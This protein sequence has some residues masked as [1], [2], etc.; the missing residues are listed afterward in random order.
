MRSPWP[1]PVPRLPPFLPRLVD[2]RGRLPLVSLAGTDLGTPARPAS[3]RCTECRRA[4]PIPEWRCA[5]CGAALH[6][7]CLASHDEIC[8]ERLACEV[9]SRRSASEIVVGPDSACDMEFWS[10]HQ[11]PV[12]HG[13]LARSDPLVWV[14]EGALGSSRSSLETRFIVNQLPLNQLVYF[15]P[16]CRSFVAAEKDALKPIHDEDELCD[17]LG[18]EAAGVCP[19]LTRS[20]AAKTRERNEV[21]RHRPGTY[22]AD[23]L[24]PHPAP[25]KPLAAKGEKGAEMG[26]ADL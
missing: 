23:P 8:M 16:V 5:E 18:E 6:Q 4:F 21:E 25:K 24:A 1:A 9:R 3:P 11:H 14:H 15:V 19:A 13:G 17:G 12:F 22:G 26:P 7:Q 2:K 10:G 20:V